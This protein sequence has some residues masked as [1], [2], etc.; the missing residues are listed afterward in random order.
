MEISDETLVKNI[1]GG[2]TESF[3]VIVERYKIQIYNLMYRYSGSAD[4]ADD[5][6]QEAFCRVYEKLGGYRSKASFFSWLYTVALNYARDW[7][8]KTQREYAKINRF[9]VDQQFSSSATEFN[10]ESKEKTQLLIE[11]LGRVSADNREI[12]ILKYRH[13]CTI[14]ELAEIFKLSESAVK[15]R[16]QRTLKELHQILKK[17]SR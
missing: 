17:R 4:E 10:Y 9:A 12:I 15:M 6:T 5:M 2:D 7:H 1:K 13:D 3:A 16:I 11:A 14:K 8:K